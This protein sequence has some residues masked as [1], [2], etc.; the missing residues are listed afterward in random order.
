[1]TIKQRI[2]R[3]LPRHQYHRF[4]QSYQRTGYLALRAL[5]QKPSQRVARVLS[6]YVSVLALSQSDLAKSVQAEQVNNQHVLFFT[7]LSGFL[8]LVAFEIAIYR[9]LQGRGYTCDLVV[10][11]RVLDFCEMMDDGQTPADRQHACYRCWRRG[12]DML[13][14]VQIPYQTASK[15]L[16]TEARRRINDLETSLLSQSIDELQN[17]VVD[18][19]H[20]GAHAIA[21]ALRFLKRGTF[22]NSGDEGADHAR[23]VLRHYVNSAIRTKFIAEASLQSARPDKVILTHGIY[24]SWGPAREVFEHAGIPVAVFDLSPIFNNAYMTSWNRPSQ[25][26]AVGTLFDH[27]QDRPLTGSEREQLAEY[28]ASRRHNTRDRTRFNVVPELPRSET[29]AQLGIPQDVLCTALFSNLLWDA[30]TVGADICFPDQL[31]WIQF[32]LDYFVHHP[33]KWLIVRPHPAE[34]LRGTRQSVVGMV[35]RLYP[36][37]PP[38][39]LL[40]ERSMDVNAYSVYNAIDAGIVN[41]STVGLEISLLGKPVIVVSGAHYRGKGFT[42]DPINRDEY[43]RTLDGLVIGERLTAHRVAEAERYAYMLFF[44]HHI[45]LPFFDDFPSTN[46]ISAARL[47]TS[48][49]QLQANLDAWLSAFEKQKPFVL[50]RV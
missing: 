45:R 29:R 13:N 37:L 5:N 43:A 30:A 1:M 19:I 10:C 33:D 26:Q 3:L 32:T 7:G 46:M 16:S 23:D 8:A 20:V 50:P 34:E 31:A 44:Q 35:R 38:N 25:A 14:G 49:P 17:L 28:L 15:I 42:F 9:T 11:D 41:T 48:D 12:E 22:P 4:K 2:V 39:I 24:V 21:A 36:A 47:E 6:D 40:M 18:N 27:E